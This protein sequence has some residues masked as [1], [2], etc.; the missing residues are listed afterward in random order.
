MLKDFFVRGVAESDGV[1]PVALHELV[2]N[3]STQHHCAGDGDGDSVEVVADRIFLDYGVDESQAAPLASERTLSD[4]REVRIVVEAV[5][6][7]NR[8]HAAVFHLPVFHNQVEEKLSYLRGIL[9]VAEAMVFDYLRNR[10]HGARVE[11]AGYVV[12]RGVPVEGLGRDIEYVFLK[13]LERFYAENLLAAFRIADYE[14]AEAEIVDDGFAEVDGEFLRVLVDES[15]TD[16]DDVVG[17][18]NLGA[19]DD[20][21]QIG[22]TLTKL[23]CEPYASLRVLDAL[24]HEGHVAYYTEDMVTVAVVEFKRLLIIAGKHHFWTSAHAQHLLML[25]ER[26]GRELAR[27]LEYEFVDNR[28]NR[29]IESHRVLDEKYH[30]D[31][32]AVNIVVGVH[33]V[34]EKFYYCEEQV[35]VAEPRKHIVYSRE[36]LVGESAR[37]LL[38]EGGE[39]ND[40]HAG[41]FGADAAC[42]GE[43]LADVVARHHYDEVEALCLHDFKSF[44]RVERAG[45]TG[46]ERTG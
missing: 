9:E 21:R 25:V 8:H 46:G 2:E 39:H 18:F 40:R 20:E 29:R 22:V 33:L 12:E 37:H 4:S 42:A 14:V 28:Q 5:F 3:V 6:L 36:I 17:V 26:L 23:A 38:G 32:Y 31:T 15:A 11:P 41:I 43:S 19:F 35:D 34:L 30:L 1:E 16:F 13:V 24:A 7:E 44:G 27:L 45:H 10:E